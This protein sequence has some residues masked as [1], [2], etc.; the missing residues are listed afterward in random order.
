MQEDG[1]IIVAGF[2]L[3][4]FKGESFKNRLTKLGEAILARCKLKKTG[5]DGWLQGEL[6]QLSGVG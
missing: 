1:V 2:I 6:I 4:S 5:S 3:L